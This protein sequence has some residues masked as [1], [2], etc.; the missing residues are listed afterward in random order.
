[1]EN[2]P[3][4]SKLGTKDKKMATK[5]KSFRLGTNI[6]TRSQRHGF[7]AFRQTEMVQMDIWDQEISGI[8]RKSKPRRS[9]ASHLVWRVFCWWQRSVDF[10][11]LSSYFIC[12]ISR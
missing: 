12:I 9:I 11:A 5:L 4:Q 10:V 8:L 3:N 1:M 7:T 2:L 6:L